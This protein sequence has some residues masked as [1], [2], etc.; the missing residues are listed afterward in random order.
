MR[1]SFYEYRPLFILSLRSI[2]QVK[3]AQALQAATEDR[4]RQHAAA[5][6]YEAELE[7]HAPPKPPPLPPTPPPPLLP[8][9]A[10]PDVDQRYALDD[11]DVWEL[12][13]EEEGGNAT[14][15]TGE[16]EEGGNAPPNTGDESSPEFLAEP[17]TEPYP[18]ASQEPAAADP[19]A[20]AAAASPEA[21]EAPVRLVNVDLLVHSTVVL[22]RQCPWREAAALQGSGALAALL[23][24]LL[25]LLEQVVAAAAAGVSVGSLSV[26]VTRVCP[27]C[28]L[29]Q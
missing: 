18:K 17:S 7:L 15:D 29:R 16:G 12:G 2:P 25:S 8:P 21:P 5:A 26:T 22:L 28:M 9:V 13:E 19:A 14:P 3:A 20:A 10:D 11:D 6:A 4:A 24:P 23:E 1:L 27:P